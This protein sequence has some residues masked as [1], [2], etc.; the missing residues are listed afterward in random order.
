M[1]VMPRSRRRVFVLLFCAAFVL[2]GGTY[3]IVELVTREGPNY[4]HIEDGLYQGGAVPSPP[5]R[6]RAVLN[7]CE[8]PD[9]YTSE[10]H[11]WEPIPDAIPVPS[12]DW[13]RA[14]VEWI[15]AQ[16]QSGKRVYVHC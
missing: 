7:L 14:R 3:L 13:L 2:I 6:T 11:V 9:P 5:W 4:S 16:R 1:R 10:V 12:I 8:S 15:D